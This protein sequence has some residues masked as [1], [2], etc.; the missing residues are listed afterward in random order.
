M[1]NIGKKIENVHS[2]GAYGNEENNEY[3]EEK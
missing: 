1:Y 2:D 3:L